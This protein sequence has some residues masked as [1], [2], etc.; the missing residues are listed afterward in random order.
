MTVKAIVIAD[1][2]NKRVPSAR[3]TT[4]EIYAPRFLLA[5]INTHRVLARSAASSR[6]IPVAKRIEA[7][8]EDPFVPNAFGKNKPGMQADETLGDF[9]TELAQTVWR[10]A[11][12]SAVTSAEILAKLKVHKQL[13]NRLLEPFAHFYGV[14]TATEWDN[15]YKLRVSPEA[16]PE[17]K[18]LATAMQDAQAASCPREAKWHLPYNPDYGLDIDLALKVCSARCARVSYRSFDGKLSAL[19]DDKRLCADLIAGGHMSPFD[20][21]AVADNVTAKSWDNPEWHRQF[22]GWIPYRVQIEQEQGYLGRRSS[23]AE[24]APELLA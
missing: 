24:I 5:E 13:A 8:L 17:F 4:F 21:C 3:I 12:T 19:E 16:Q 10:G 7:V 23:F 6:A 9:E 11:V 14:V 1:T 18:D 15:F 2:F 20:H 22:W